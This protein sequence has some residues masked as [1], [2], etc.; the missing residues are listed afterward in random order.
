MP[1]TLIVRNNALKIAKNPQIMYNLNMSKVKQYNLPPLSLWDKILFF[2]QF[3]T[4]MSASIPISTTLASIKKHTHHAEI[5]Y[6]VHTLLKEID[7]GTNFCDAILKFKKS[8]GAIYCNLMSL[9]AQAGE[10]PQVLEDI[11]DALKKQKE[12]IF[13]IIRQSIY[14]AFLFFGLLIPATCLLFF[15]IAPRM[16]QFHETLT[17][18]IPT[19]ILQI[20]QIGATLANNWLILIIGTIIAIWGG[21]ILTKNIIRKEFGLKLPLIGLLVKNYNLSLFTRLLAIS[22]RAGVPITHGILLAAEAVPNE[23]IKKTLTKCSPMVT[24]K[25]FTD[26]FDSTRLFTPAMIIK[27]ETGEQSGELDKLLREISNDID[28][29][30]ELAVTS[31]LKIMEPLLMLIMAGFIVLYATTI[32]KTIM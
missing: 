30:L 19:Q 1:D 8:L 32:L 6:I 29:A 22:Y 31:A 18:Q 12:L 27:L 9:G 7:K 26:T 28:K 4:Y 11:H 16:G 3:K 15:F 13:S 25:S 21:V 20:Q 5:R 24:K 10:L 17:G 23:Y 14:P 2:E